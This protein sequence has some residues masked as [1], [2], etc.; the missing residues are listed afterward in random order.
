MPDI[1]RD[2]EGRTKVYRN[3]QPRGMKYK[4]HALGYEGQ[5]TL[6][7]MQGTGGNRQERQPG[8]GTVGKMLLGQCLSEMTITV[9]Q[10]QSSLMFLD[11]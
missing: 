3:R 9:V 2:T 7:T 11:P 10:F 6:G 4:R 1:G 8:T 5:R